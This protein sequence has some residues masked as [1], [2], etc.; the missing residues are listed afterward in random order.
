ML[1]WNPTETV[2]VEGRIHRQGNRQGN[3]HIV[4]PLM[5]DS[6]DSFMYQKHDEKSQRIS[7]IFSYKGDSLNV[8]DIDPEA[9]KFGLIKDPAKRADMRINELKAGLRDKILLAQ[10]AADKLSIN[11]Q[12]RQRLRSETDEYTSEIDA[13]KKA[14]K[15]FA[16]L[17]DEQMQKK[18]DIDPGETNIDI[19]VEEFSASGHA[20]VEAKSI[21]ELRKNYEKQSR[22][23]IQTAQKSIA[24]AKGKLETIDNTLKRYNVNPESTAEVSAAVK[25]YGGE[26]VSLKKEIEKI[27]KDRKSYIARAEA[28]IRKEAKPGMSVDEAVK[29]ATNSIAGN[30]VP[31][32]EVEKRIKAARAAAVGLNKAIRRQV[33]KILVRWVG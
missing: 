3:V 33:K 4:Y 21:Q 12:N 15:E 14:S 2:Q 28:D 32:E 30:L 27:E 25:R 11:Y 23:F 26:A 24:S 19:R 5:N 10:A 9:L 1:G 6:V 7:A 13:L 20:W 29:A 31:M 17:T 22:G 18:Y 8:E 16:S